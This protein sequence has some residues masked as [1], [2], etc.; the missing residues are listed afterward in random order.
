MELKFC[1]KCVMDGSAKEL[2]LDD[3][4]V[5]NFCH[6]AQAEL[7]LAELEKPNLGL[8]INQIKQDGKDRDYD[9]LIGL[10]GGVDSST[11]LHK[12]VK[13][14]GLKPLCY[15]ID[16]G[17]N[18]PKADENI[19]R[20]VET[21]KVPFYRYLIDLVKFREL[22]AAF[23]Q[24]GLINLEIPTDHI[25]FASSLEMAAKYNIKWILS[26]GNINSESIMPFSW[27]YHARD[28][29]HISAVYKWTTG[30]RLKGLPTCS[31]LG[32]NWYKWIKGIR[33]FYLLDYLD[34]NRKESEQMLIKEYGFQSTGEKHEESLFTRWFQNF[35]LFQKW[36]ID[37]R[38]A[39][40]SSM[41]NSGQMSRE[42]ASYLLTA[43]PVFPEFGIEQKVMKYPKR[44]HF[45]FPT[46]MR[47]YNTMSKIV[48]RLKWIFQKTLKTSTQV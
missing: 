31:F 28:L 5:C 43:N 35:Y 21:L 19:M 15:T 32:F 11:L 40:Y 3:N 24:A 36:N 30:K 16:N 17:Y 25:L 41:I 4:G 42:E 44:S 7:L 33:T 38:K 14:F 2:V 20:M 1:S 45:D 23:M 37:K 9:C 27:S 47:L 22:Q 10:S 29:R 13:E 39:H 48:K 6:I 46:N 8:R 12:A 34:Y 26:G 18:D